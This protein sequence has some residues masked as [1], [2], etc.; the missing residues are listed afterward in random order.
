MVTLN[1]GHKAELKEINNQ[2]FDGFS[3]ND[4]LFCPVCNSILCSHEFNKITDLL[5]KHKY[6][7]RHTIY[8]THLFP[9]NILRTI[10]EPGKLYQSLHN[11]YMFWFEKYPDWDSDEDVFNETRPDIIYFEKYNSDRFNKISELFDGDFSND[12]ISYRFVFK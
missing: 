2:F 11:F 10:V 6:L 1:C 12:R 9:T 7:Q 8:E 5:C 3:T 4:N